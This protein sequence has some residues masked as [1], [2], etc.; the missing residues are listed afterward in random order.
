MHV[1]EHRL[2]ASLCT[3]NKELTIGNVD[4]RTCNDG[5]KSNVSTKL[6]SLLLF[7]SYPKMKFSFYMKLFVRFVL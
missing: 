4:V 2:S 6:L 1:L 3:A 7:D 5:H